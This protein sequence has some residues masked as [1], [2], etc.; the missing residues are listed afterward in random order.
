MNTKT[1]GI[2]HI[3]AITGDPQANINFYEGFLGQRLIKKTVNFDDP[4]AYHLYYG[5]AVGTP[6]TILTFFYWQGLPASE[7]GVGE[8]S[9][10]YYAIP[11]ESLYFWRSRIQSFAI[12]YTEEIL[13]F[14]ETVLIIHDPDGLLIGLV[15]TDVESNVVPWKEGTVPEEHILRGFYGASIAVAKNSMIETALT[16]GLGYELL[17]TKD[18]VLRYQATSW[19]G[20]YLAIQERPDL[21]PARQGAGSVHHIA[22]QANTDE[23]CEALSTQ[24]HATGLSVT[25]LI[26]RQY[27]HSTYFMTPA[28]VLFEIA[29][30]DIGFTLDEPE[31]ELGENL[32]L[33]PQYESARSD[34]E[35]QLLPVTLPRHDNTEQH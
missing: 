20:K 22:F 21:P 15:A 18:T 2:H 4:T 5:D 27:F 16:E 34:I 1:N 14:G 23:E 7:R 28:G 11:P 24:V 12:D 33:P 8:M 35:S 30:N 9:G 19:P 26:D 17:E 6:G 25:N 10:M 29:T 32:K 31:T 13:P 3:T